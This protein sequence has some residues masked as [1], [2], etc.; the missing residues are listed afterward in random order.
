MSVN[1]QCVESEAS[2]TLKSS[3]RLL[4]VLAL[5]G[6][7]ISACLPDTPTCGV[8]FFCHWIVWF[9]F[10]C[11]NYVGAVKKFSTLKKNKI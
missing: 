5:S 3:A 11:C 2:V 4:F 1:I 9:E 8:L 10:L 6:D 7:L